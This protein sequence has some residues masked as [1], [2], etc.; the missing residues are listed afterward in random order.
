LKTHRAALC[1][2]V[3]TL[4]LFPHASARSRQTAAAPAPQDKPDSG[5]VAGSTYSNKYFGLTLTIPGG[6][7]VLAASATQ[8]MKEAG[9][10][11]V[12]SDDPAKKAQLEEAVNKTLILLNASQYTDG[13]AVPFNPGLLCGAEKVP[14]P[15]KDADYMKVLKG[16]FQYAQVPVS[17]ERDVYPETLGG[18]GFSVI[19]VK[20]TL[21]QGVVLQKYYAHII[22][23]YALFFILTYQTDEQLQT[24]ADALRSVRFQ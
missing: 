1:V 21:P 10:S 18:V 7:H 5:A 19:D 13:A 3:F 2:L 17:L 24:Q 8:E 9:K 4:S 22:K 12:T 20:V 23:D 11:L 16:T 14:A 6:W 15:L